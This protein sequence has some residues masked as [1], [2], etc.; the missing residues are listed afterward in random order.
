MMKFIWLMPVALC[1][2][3]LQVQS[4]P[5]ADGHSG[6]VV[7]RLDAPAGKE[8]VALQWDLEFAANPLH[9]DVTKVAAGDA[10]KTA[11]KSAACSLIAREKRDL[12]RYRCILAGGVSL[13]ASG[14]IVTI[15]YAA[16]QN[17]KAGRYPLRL[18]NGLAVGKNLEKDR[19]KDSGAEI[20]VNK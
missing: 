17:A 5:A 19:V 14:P 2:Q 13:L 7:I 12:L 3:T 4:E 6:T 11:G 16:E 9:V 20:T 8:P 15:P 18:K 10:A 1:G